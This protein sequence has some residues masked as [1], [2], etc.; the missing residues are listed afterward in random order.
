VAGV[1]AIHV[2]VGWIATS[3]FT[4]LAMT[5]NEESAEATGLPGIRRWRTVYWVVF[6]IFVLWVGLL[7]WLT[8]SYS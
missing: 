5:N 1:E 8:R 3:G 7:T 2:P 4:R 6:G